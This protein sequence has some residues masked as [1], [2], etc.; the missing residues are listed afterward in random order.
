MT[1]YPYFFSLSH[2]EDYVM[3][4]IS[5]REV[6]AD[7]QK[8]RACDVMKPA[9][10][11]FSER[12]RERLRRC[13][14]E[15]K[16]RELFYE[17]W[18]CKEAYGKLTGKGLTEAIGL[19]MTGCIGCETAVF[20]IK[21]TDIVIKRRK[22]SKEYKAAVCSFLPQPFAIRKY[23]PRDCRQIAALFFQTVHTVNAK[24]YT[25]EQLDVWATGVVDLEVWNQSFQENETVVAVLG[26][27]I[28]GFGDMDGTG[29]LN[30]LYVHKDYQRQGVASAIC[31]RL[32]Q[33]FER[34]RKAERAQGGTKAVGKIIT[35]ASVTARPFFEKRG[36]VAVKEQQVER[37]GI[38]LTNFVM[39]KEI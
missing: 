2:S 31:S 18:T 38:L 29:C 19:D 6:G 37:Q 16:Q 20:S 39:E 5:E 26:E 28:V 35:H 7:I 24:D 15:A 27:N 1:N 21:G 3:C 30:R 33:A 12:E 11:F 23:S 8:M 9:E 34:D 14:D 32:E 25:R 22:V 4:A 13:S 17:L 36:Y 10:R